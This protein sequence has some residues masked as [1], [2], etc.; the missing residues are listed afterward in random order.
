MYVDLQHFATVSLPQESAVFYTDG[1][2]PEKTMENS[3]KQNP[4]SGFKSPPST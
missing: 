1:I 3:A 4:E 2:P